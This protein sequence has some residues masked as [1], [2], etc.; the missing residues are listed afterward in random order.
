MRH[1]FQHAEKKRHKAWALATI[2]LIRYTPEQLPSKHANV[3][4]PGASVDATVMAVA[5]QLE[6]PTP[7]RRL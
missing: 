3:A 5:Q 4:F 6:K 1:A 2:L 7:V